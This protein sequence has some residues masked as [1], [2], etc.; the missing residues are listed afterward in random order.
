MR[1][2]GCSQR[3]EGVGSREERGTTG[4]GVGGKWLEVLWMLL[5][6]KFLGNRFYGFV[7]TGRCLGIHL[8][9][10]D[11]LKHHLSSSQ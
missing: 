3:E 11:Y 8:S 4:V 7:D 2:I 6:V 1:R 5:G 10:N 9:Y